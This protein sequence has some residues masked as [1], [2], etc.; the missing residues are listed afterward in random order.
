MT[1]NYIVPLNDYTLD[2]I[3]DTYFLAFYSSDNN[4]FER[5][6]NIYNLYFS[7]E[8]PTETITLHGFLTSDVYISS[9]QFKIHTFFN[10]NNNYVEIDILSGKE[11]VVS[12]HLYY[13]Y[14]IKDYIQKVPDQTS[15]TCFNNEYIFSGMT[16]LCLDCVIDTSNENRYTITIPE[17]KV[18][19]CD[20][21]PNAIFLLRT[22]PSY[23]LDEMW[24]VRN[25]T[26][27]YLSNDCYVLKNTYITINY[28]NVP[29]L[30]NIYGIEDATI[31]F[32]YIP[33]IRIENDK[34]I[35]VIE[36]RNFIIDYAR[37][38]L[39]QISNE[40]INY[41]WY[42]TEGNTISINDDISFGKDE[43]HIT[44]KGVMD[45]D[46]EGHK[47]L[48]FTSNSVL[49]MDNLVVP[50]N[51]ILEIS[52]AE[53]SYITSMELEGTLICKRIESGPV[54]IENVEFTISE[55]KDDITIH[56]TQEMFSVQNEKYVFRLP[57][58]K[59]NKT[60]N[61]RFDADVLKI[62]SYNTSFI[63][64]YE[65]GTE[66]HIYVPYTENLIKIN[67]YIYMDSSIQESVTDTVY[68]ITYGGWT[69]LLGTSVEKWVEV[70]SKYEKNGENV[71][72]TIPKNVHFSNEYSYVLVP[73]ENPIT[74]DIS[75][76]K[77]TLY[78]QDGDYIPE[79]DPEI[80]IE[81][82]NNN[83]EQTRSLLPSDTKRIQYG[84]GYI[85]FQYID[86]IQEITSQDKKEY[87]VYTN[88]SS[89]TVQQ[90]REGLEIID[91]GYV[92]YGWYT[93]ND[94][95]NTFTLGETL[96]CSEQDVVV[97]GAVNILTNGYHDIIDFEKGESII[98]PSLEVKE[99]QNVEVKEA[100][101][102][103]IGNCSVLGRF[104]CNSLIL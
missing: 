67:G 79:S 64:E 104:K 28:Y 18:V 6:V 95:T 14:T 66:E 15:Q 48:E 63:I 91:N 55:K 3:N 43:D 20:L 100:D 37:E 78:F 90:C 80:Y 35:T 84:D 11:I 54:F 102:M 21:T 53:L 33:Q 13:D 98:A 97:Y 70:I 59:I 86:D 56:L 40:Y 47:E 34:Q 41:G 99:N 9:T 7:K 81:Y 27:I 96:K 61:V 71:Y 5:N 25:N 31:Y 45:I 2:T 38:K 57:I 23:T 24:T 60:I 29:N 17:G 74:I 52:G 77:I 19:G 12:G 89:Y 72:I 88:D 26:Y 4:L 1:K 42:D 46:E 58:Q 36:S 51:R 22:S 87:I 101:V 62:F 82:K 73:E 93:L 92:N 85:Y 30:N 44:I 50:E 16:V 69:Y 49:K 10:I 39:V 32:E 76:D 65:Y 8:I 75:L 94:D 68:G 83:E 103:V